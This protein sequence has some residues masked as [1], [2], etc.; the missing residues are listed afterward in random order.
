MIEYAASGKPS[1]SEREKLAI[2]QEFGWA[3]VEEDYT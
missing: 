2:V 3:S 1:S